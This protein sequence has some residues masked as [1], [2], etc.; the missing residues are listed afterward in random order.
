MATVGETV[1]HPDV[2]VTCTKA[3][4]DAYLVPEVVVVFEVLSPT[5]GRTDR[6]AKLREYRTVPS[7]RRY[8]ILE[9]AGI[10]L[11]VLARANADQNWIATA[12]T[13][14]DV[15]RLPELGAEIP[16]AELYEGVDLAAAPDEDT[17]KLPA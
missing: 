15:L 5:S 4:G 3:A 14:D 1:R 10:G 17:D 13:A 9:H 12:Q 2:L 6:I 7:I 11:I 16:V 8:V